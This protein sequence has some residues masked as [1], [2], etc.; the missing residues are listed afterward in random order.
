MILK[1]TTLLIAGFLILSSDLFSQAGTF[2]NISND[3]R[4][5][6]MGNTYV[7]SS[8]GAFS[9]FGNLSAMDQSDS[10]AAVGVSYRPWISNWSSDYNLTSFSGHSFKGKHTLAVGM[11]LF[12]NPGYLMTDDQGN[13]LG[14]FKPGEKTFGLGYSY[15]LSDRTALSATV[16]SLS[17]ELSKDYSGSSVYADLGLKTTFHQVDFGLMVRN[18]GSALR[19]E[20]TSVALPLTLVT[21]VAYEKLMGDKQALRGNADVSYVSLPDDQSGLCAGVGLEYEYNNR[22]ALRG[23]YHFC[24]ETVGLSA[25]SLGA[26]LNLFGGSIDFAWLIADNA[27]KNNF[28]VGCSWAF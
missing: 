9:F 14:E 2:I 16:H 27:L 5:V 13:N 15:R 22:F 10:K 26:G 23:G 28:C 1:R 11:R 20:S 4:S 19:F 7:A 24:D 17:T 8:G 25:L 18:L 12:S 21:G 6:A 3:P